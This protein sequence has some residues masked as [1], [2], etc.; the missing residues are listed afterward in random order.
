MHT[1][2]QFQFERRQIERGEFRVLP[3]VFKADEM[4]KQGLAQ[5]CG[6]V[7]IQI[8]GYDEFQLSTACIPEVR[9]FLRSLAQCWNPRSAAFFCD[10]HSAFF[11]LY[12]LSQLDHLLVVEHDGTADCHLF[13]WREELEMFRHEAKF[14]ITEL[15]LR[16]SLAEE[17]IR[18]RQREVSELLSGAFMHPFPS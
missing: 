5:Y 14:G 12:M 15:G 7:E 1:K 4:T 16:A 18:E 13:Y 3:A 17:D 9:I 8:R 6:A 11:R 2:I 10:L